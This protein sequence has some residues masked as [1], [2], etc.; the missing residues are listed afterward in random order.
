M[1]SKLPLTHADLVVSA[2]RW[3]LNHGG[4]GIAFCELVCTDEI[5]DVIGFGQWGGRSVLIECKT[6]RSDF[7]ADRKKLFRQHPFL[8]MGQFRFYCCPTGL[9][10]VGDLPDKWGL[11]YV[12]E[13]GVPKCVHNPY[14]PH[15]GNYWQNGFDE[16]N[17]R[18]ERRIMYSALI[19][20]K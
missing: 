2:K 15:G 20:Q 12:N 9:L 13:R 17:Q 14:N 1:P 11:I 6:S 18:S 3:V 7:L 4:C 10:S 19:R 8:G 16:W 5:A